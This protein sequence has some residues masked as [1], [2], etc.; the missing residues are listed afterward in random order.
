MNEQKPARI[1]CSHIVPLKANVGYF[2]NFEDYFKCN[3][4]SD[5]TFFLF[6]VPIEK[7]AELNCVQS[8]A[9]QSDNIAIYAYGYTSKVGGFDVA[10]NYFQTQEEMELAKDHFMRNL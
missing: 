5:Y 4:K 2:D 6:T 8:E 7:V 1:D 9:L 10:F 3:K